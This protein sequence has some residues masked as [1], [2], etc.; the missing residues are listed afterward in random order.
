MGLNAAE[1]LEKNQPYN[2]LKDL[3]IKTNS[4]IVDARCLDAW[5]ENGYF[6]IK[7][8]NKEEVIKEFLAIREDLKKAANKGIESVDFFEDM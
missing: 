2:S 3:A 7:K 4:S 5:I 8:K 6:S 1:E